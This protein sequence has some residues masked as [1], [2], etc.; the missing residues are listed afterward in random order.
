MNEDRDYEVGY[1]KPPKASRFQ[2]GRSGNPQGRPKQAKQPNQAPSMAAVFRKVTNQKVRTNGQN[3]QQDMTKLE[4][5]VTQ[6]VNKAA[7]GDLRA[8][9]LMLRTATQFPELIKEP[10]PERKV[11]IHFV[12][13]KYQEQA[14]SLDGQKDDEDLTGD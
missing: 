8:M 3:G 9:R 5:S 13:P 7:S 14:A 4:A 2:K 10:F 11:H 12:T 1:G 6:L